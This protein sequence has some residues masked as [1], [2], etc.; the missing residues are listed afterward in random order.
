MLDFYNQF[1]DFK[2]FEIAFLNSKKEL[3]KLLCNIKSIESNRIVLNANNQ[4]NKNIFAE[5]GDELKLHIYTENGIYSATARVLLVTRGLVSTEYII[6]YP[7]NSKHSQRREYFRAEIPVKFI[8]TVFPENNAEPYV[9]E[10][11]AQNVCGKGMSYIA[12]APFPDY[13]S[14]ELEM[15]FEER[16]I[17]TSAELVYTRPVQIGGIPHFINAFTLTSISKRDI[18][19]IVKQC[20]LHQLHL[21][22]KPTY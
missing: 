12:Q 22:K 11:T 14:L 19:F 21:K 9:I 20:F 17:K 8:L 7:A 18:E 3:Q 5:V 1:K 2:A 4:K 15:F 13:Y 10:A 16:S 6:S